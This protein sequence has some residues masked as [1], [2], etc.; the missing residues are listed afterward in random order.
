MPASRDL[1]RSVCDTYVIRSWM[2]ACFNVKCHSIQSKPVTPPVRHAQTRQR[3]QRPPA[4]PRKTPR[5]SPA[6]LCPRASDPRN[7]DL[8]L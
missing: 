7:A 5:R 6:S 4:P 3:E 2:H 1:L 8:A